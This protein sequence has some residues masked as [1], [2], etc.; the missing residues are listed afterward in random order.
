MSAQKSIK[1]NYIYNLSYQILLL[2]T[3]FITTPYVSRVLCADGIGTVSYTDSV[4]SYF[5]L[6]ATMGV[7]TYG[8]REISYVQKS[9]EDR[10]VVFWNTKLLEFC[11][12]GI[13]M[14]AYTIFA[15][16]QDNTTLYLI[17]GFN[18]VAVFFDV[19]WFFQGMEEFG[20]IVLRNVIF[21][22]ISIVYIF[23]VVKSKDDLI[24][25]VIGITVFAVI[26][27]ISLWFYLPKYINKVDVR[28]IHPF[29]NIGTVISLFIPTIAIQIYTVLDKTMIGV[30]TK[31]EFENG[32]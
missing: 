31:N 8:Q 23:A 29:Q 20:K 27:N 5:V 18:I 3:P 22:V 11:T 30:I 10:S 32:Y 19:T 2:I 28:L 7:T 4:V 6:F 26:S 9:V 13:L 21:K 12:A 25:Y 15:F 24:L 1:K 16:Q 14:V 17:Y